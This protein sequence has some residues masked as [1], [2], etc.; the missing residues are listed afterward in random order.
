MSELDDDMQFVKQFFFN[1]TQIPGINFALNIIYYIAVGVFVWPLYFVWRNAPTAWGVGGWSGKS[2]INICM[3]MT[4]LDEKHWNN[5][6]RHKLCNEHIMKSFHKTL[7]LWFSMIMLMY[8]TK[9]IFNMMNNIN[10]LSWI[11]T[12]IDYFS[13]KVFGRSNTQPQQIENSSESGNKL[14]YY[15][16]KHKPGVFYIEKSPNKGKTPSPPSASMAMLNSKN[17]RRISPA[18]IKPSTPQ[19][20]PPS[21]KKQ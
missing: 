5:Q 20:T 2:D 14:L 9:L 13:R 16:S 8:A 6:I 19:K 7:L 17:F 10:V 21:L 12:T 18:R 15:T 1:L 3:D 4:G 11:F